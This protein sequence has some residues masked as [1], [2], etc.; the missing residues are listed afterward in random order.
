MKMMQ[1]NGAGGNFE[2]TEE[3]M[4]EPAAGYVR[5]KVQACGICHSDSVTKDG[6]LPGNRLSAL[7]R[8]RDRWA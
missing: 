2:L 6:L 4:R 7:A 3:P 5:V 1:V 8:P